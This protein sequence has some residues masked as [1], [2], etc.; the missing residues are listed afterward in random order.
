MAVLNYDEYNDSNDYQWWIDAP[1]YMMCF[2]C[3]EWIRKFQMYNYCPHCGN[4]LFPIV[5]KKAVI[6]ERLDAI[7]KEVKAIK[8]ELSE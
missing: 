1:A 7:L 4:H 5:D 3:Y 8:E 2:H 6:L